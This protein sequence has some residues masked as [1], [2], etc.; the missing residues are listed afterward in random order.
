MVEAAGANQD[1]ELPEDEL[2][3]Q[4]ATSSEDEQEDDA[5]DAGALAS[6]DTGIDSEDRL[7]QDEAV[8]MNELQT[9][10]EHA[11][12]PPLVSETDIADMMAVEAAFAAEE[13]DSSEEEDS[14]SGQEQSAGIPVEVYPAIRAGV[15]TTQKLEI[16][17]A[18]AK[19][20]SVL[21]TL[22]DGSPYLSIAD[23]TGRIR[24]TL[25]LDSEGDARLTFVDEMGAETWMA[26]RD[27]PPPAPEPEQAHK[28]APTTPDTRKSEPAGP[29]S[30]GSKS[31]PKAATPPT[32][33]KPGELKASR[34]SSPPSKGKPS[35]KS[36]AAAAP[37]RKSTKIARKTVRRR[38]TVRSVGA[39]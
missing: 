16:V 33:P 8:I 35:K 17:D 36:T 20:R 19:V 7:T 1:S 34:P 28:Q 38:K 4:E 21:A 11:P 22:R 30:N 26:P 10:F 9:E 2:S 13:S 12:E 18:D 37:R 29:G 3:E 32:R 23:A 27:E 14:P 6:P 39:R 5:D 25:R 24:V 31:R 15:V